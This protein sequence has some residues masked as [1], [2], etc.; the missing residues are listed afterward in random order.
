LGSIPALSKET[1]TF[2]VKSKNAGGF[3]NDVFSF[4]KI[5]W[6][7]LLKVMLLA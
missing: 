5:Y 3:I 2:F 6:M 4:G 1:F 7:S